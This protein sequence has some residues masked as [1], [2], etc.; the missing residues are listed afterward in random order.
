MSDDEDENATVVLDVNE[1]KKQIAAGPTVK[2]ENALSD[3][4]SLQFSVDLD[5]SETK[6]EIKKLPLFPVLCF[7]FGNSLFEEMKTNFPSHLDVKILT[8]LK[9]LNSELAEKK[10]KILFLNY[11]GSSAAVNQ[12]S[13]QIR[14]KFSHCK[15]VIVAKGLNPEKAKKHAQ[16]A[17]GADGYLSHPLDKEKLSREI[18]RLFQKFNE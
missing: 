7:D 3:D 14:E 5:D 6:T 8:E 2:E 12:V 9:E 4:I 18:E 13:K 16:T 10:F 17:S 1:L 11:D 15:T